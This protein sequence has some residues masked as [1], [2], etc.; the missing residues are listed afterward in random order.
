MPLDKHHML[1]WIMD[2]PHLIPTY[3]STLGCCILRQQSFIWGHLYI[4]VFNHMDFMDFRTH[5]NG[6]GARG[7]FF[8]CKPKAERLRVGFFLASFLNLASFPVTLS[9]GTTILMEASINYQVPQTRSHQR[10]HCGS[11][12]KPWHTSEIQAAQYN[13]AVASVILTLFQMARGSN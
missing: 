7:W 2:F 4:I 1:T 12:G 5:P 10:V 13:S 8:S 6:L 11:W 9:R 3:I